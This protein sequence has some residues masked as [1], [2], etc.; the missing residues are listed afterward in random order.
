M[1]S[2]RDAGFQE[3]SRSWIMCSRCNVVPGTGDDQ[4]QVWQSFEWG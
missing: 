1:I 2:N 3:G 4:F